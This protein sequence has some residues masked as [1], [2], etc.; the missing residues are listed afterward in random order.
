MRRVVV[1]GLGMVS[2][3]GCGVEPTWKRALDGMSGAKQI[4]TFDVTD[5]PCR[6]ACVVPRGDGTDG[7]FNPDQWMEP[8]D[9]RKV[10]DFI[11]FAI[12]SRG[13]NDENSVPK[14]RR[15]LEIAL[16]FKPVNLGDSRHGGAYRQ[17]VQRRAHR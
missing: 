3:L 11:V 16:Q 12:A 2:P 1:T 13:K 8:K 4:E 6:I 7:T 14:L 15:F 10:D 9:Q 17:A 5:L